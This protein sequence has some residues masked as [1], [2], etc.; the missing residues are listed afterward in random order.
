LIWL[1][2]LILLKI[3]LFYLPPSAARWQNDLTG[4]V[5]P[6]PRIKANVSIGWSRDR[7]SAN[8]T[9]R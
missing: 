7:H 9:G 3:S 4:A 5:P 8:I 6:M 1:T 2:A